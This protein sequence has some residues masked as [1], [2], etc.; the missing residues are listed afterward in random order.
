MAVGFIISY[1]EMDEMIFDI[2]RS[3]KFHDEIAYMDMRGVDRIYRVF[4]DI[5]RDELLGILA[6]YKCEYFILV[7]DRWKESSLLSSVAI[8]PKKD[9]LHVIYFVARQEGYSSVKQYIYDVLAD[10]GV[11]LGESVDRGEKD[12]ARYRR[13]VDALKDAVRLGKPVRFNDDYVCNVCGELWDV[14]GVVREIDMTKEE[15]ERFL[16]GKGCPVCRGRKSEI[17]LELS[18]K[19]G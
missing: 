8:V 10:A 11:F 15:K 9:V 4:A 13:L 12:E 16:A 2:A 5:L 6:D 17:V 3:E 14:K 7:P 1:G 18:G 19:V